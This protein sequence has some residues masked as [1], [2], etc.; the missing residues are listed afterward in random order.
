MCEA[1]IAAEPNLIVE[2]DNT[3]AGGSAATRSLLTKRST[4]P[5]AIFA[6]NDQLACGALHGARRSGRRVP[7]DLAVV[8]FDNT[9]SSAF[10]TPELT[11]VA[12]ERNRFTVEMLFAMIDGAP[13]PALH[14]TV[15]VTLVIRESCGAT[16]D[17]AH[18]RKKGK[19]D[20][21]R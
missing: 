13:I 5:T 9:V 14:Q 21:K 15:P 1:G 16:A 12:H 6:Y 3:L 11:T 10:S 4:S 17:K 19:N 2:T 18:K 7:D 20:A 8:G